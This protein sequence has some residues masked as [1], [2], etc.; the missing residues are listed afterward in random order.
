M[1]NVKKCLRIFIKAKHLISLS[2]L[3]SLSG[4]WIVGK[5]YDT[6]GE[7]YF[8]RD[9]SD[10]YYYFYRAVTRT[11]RY[12]ACPAYIKINCWKKYFDLGKFLP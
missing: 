5:I 10:Y 6:F 12:L 11:R 7:D 8:T 9:T 1:V 3:K 2:R 4:H